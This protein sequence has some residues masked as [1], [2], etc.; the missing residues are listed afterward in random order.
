MLTLFRKV[1]KSLIE[2][3]FAK[4]Y[5]LYAI[6]ETLLVMVG[7]LLALQVNNWNNHRL[8]LKGEEKILFQLK[9][10]FDNN[11]NQFLKIQNIHRNFFH[12]MELLQNY[13]VNRAEVKYNSDSLSYALGWLG[14][15]KTATYNPSVSVINS[16]IN[17]GKMDIIK[18][19]SLRV[20]LIGWNELISDYQEEELN[21]DAFKANHVVP[22][23]AKEVEMYHIGVTMHGNPNSDVWASR[24]FKSLL[25]AITHY[26]YFILDDHGLGDAPTLSFRLERIVS[27]LNRELQERFKH[28]FPDYNEI[29]V[30]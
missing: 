2:S 14:A 5:F 25:A 15:A 4:K 20:L 28:N 7:I 10:E 11:H 26:K 1:R 19:D 21:L 17:S 22:F 3:G 23:M 24:Q 18:N 13:I 12:Q 29:P 9:E 16:L 6:G 27:L 8:E 30:N